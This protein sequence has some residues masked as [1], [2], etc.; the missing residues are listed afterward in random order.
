MNNVSL[1]GRLTA[2]PELRA[3]A[4]GTPVAGLRLAFDDHR[5]QTTGD[6][7]PGF[8]TVTTWGKLAETLTQHKRKGDEIAVTG[9]LHF[10]TW[11]ADDG[12]TR[13]ML[14]I[15]AHNI[16]FLRNK[17]PAEDQPSMTHADHL[18]AEPESPTDVGLQHL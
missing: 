7:V 4:Q 1:I 10:S 5:S 18:A 8:V 13:S 14:E 3:T 15:V 9:R 17:R 11:T 6:T 2:D 12:Q 16:D